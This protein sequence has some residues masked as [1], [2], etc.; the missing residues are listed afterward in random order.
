MQTPIATRKDAQFVHD[1][2]HRRT[3]AHDIDALVDLYLSDAILESPLVP[4]IMDRPSGVLIGHDQ[5]REFFHRGTR[6]RP[7]DIA[8]S[9]R[10]GAFLFENGCLVW[11]YPR[12]APEGDQLDIIEVMDLLGTKIR[13]HRIYWGWFGAPLLQR[14]PAGT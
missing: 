7:T 14:K 1:E 4:R 9:Y 8:R 6:G 5:L 11:E 10:T 3:Y 12:Q 13:H 2:W